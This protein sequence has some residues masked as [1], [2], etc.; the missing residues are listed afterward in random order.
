MLVT[1]QNLTEKIDPQLQEKM[2]RVKEKARLVFERFP[3]TF[4][5]VKSIMDNSNSLDEYYDKFEV[6]LDGYLNK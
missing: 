2:D 3:D 5:H 6:F 1:G 4:S